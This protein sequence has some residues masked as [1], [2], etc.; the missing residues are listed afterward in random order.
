MAVLKLDVE[1]LELMVLLP[2][3]VLLLVAAVVLLSVLC[4][5]VVFLVVFS[6][7]SLSVFNVLFDFFLNF[8]FLREISN[9]VKIT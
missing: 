2:L 4:L 5:A 7:V 9:I 1:G 8:Y 6:D 3:V